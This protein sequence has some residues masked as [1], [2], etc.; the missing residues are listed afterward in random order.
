M[1][2]ASKYRPSKLKADQRLR[3]KHREPFG[4]VMACILLTEGSGIK[5][6]TVQ[7]ADTS[8]ASLSVVPD[9]AEVGV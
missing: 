1:S 9:T 4:F 8:A 6:G 5:P 7:R 3:S 2:A